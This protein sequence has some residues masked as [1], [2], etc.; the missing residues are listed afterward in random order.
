[1]KKPEKLIV[2]KLKEK[3]GKLTPMMEQYLEIKSQYRDVL[4]LFRMGDFYEV[5]FEDA[6]AT[7][8]ILNIALTHRGKLAGVPIPMAGIPHHAASTYID[9][10]TQSGRK[11]AICEQ[12]EDPKQAKGI[13]KR[14]VTQIVSPSIPY[15]LDKSEERH[16]HYLC[17]FHFHK[18]VTYAS[19]IDYTTGDFFGLEIK[20]QEELFD[21]IKIYAPRECIAFFDQ[22]ERRNELREFLENRDVLITYLSSEFFQEKITASYIEKIIPYYKKDN[23]LKTHKEFIPPIGALSYYICSTQGCEKLSHFSAFSV[24]NNQKKMKISHQTLASLEI[25]PRSQEKFSHSLLAFINKTKTSMGFRK[26][27]EFSQSPLFDKNEI[28][29]RLDCVEFLMANQSDL[30]NIRTELDEIRDLKRILAK[31]STGKIQSQDL[32]N[33]KVAIET[34]DKLTK[35][36]KK[37]T[38]Y[39]PSHLDKNQL[40][41]LDEL[42]I[43]IGKAINDE[44]GANLNKGNLIKEKYSK[45]RDELANIHET[46]N[47]KMKALEDKYRKKHDISNL[48]IKF[49]N[50]NGYFIEVSKAQLAK[51]PETFK[52]KQTLVNCGRFLTAEVQKV[53]AELYSA[54][55]KLLQI[56]R[57]IF[58]KICKQTEDNVLAIQ[59]LADFLAT[60]DIYQSF[61]WLA[62]QENFSRPQI[63]DKKICHLEGVWHPLIKKAIHDQ[64][65]PHNIELNNKQY[66]ALITGPNM[67]GKTT[68]MREV[69][70]VQFLTQMGSYVPAA[71]AQ[72]GLCDYI[73]SRIGASD[74]IVGGQSTFM[75]EMSE[76]SEILRH[77]SEHSLLILDEIG[78]GTST[79]DGLSIAWS[80]LEHFCEKTKALTL[81]ST[82]YH[83]LIDVAE[84][85][86]G[87]INLTVK[88]IN[89]NGT[90]QFLYELIPGGAT[91]S[92]G[93]HVAKLAGLPS[94][95]LKRANQILKQLEKEQSPK[96]SFATINQMN[97]FDSGDEFEEKESMIE[98][99]IREIDINSMTPIE[100]LNKFIEFQTTLQKSWEDSSSL[101]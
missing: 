35:K 96:D 32:L 36:I 57:E 95:V 17:S 78:R 9:K 69:A 6:E 55:E 68:V 43:L 56:E 64:F 20:S 77:A 45:K 3:A 22:F 34:F 31:L 7:S 5:F 25:F 89:K 24:I 85:T 99:Q 39:L 66:F 71:K 67:A 100:A 18:N 79:F 60:L 47:S 73:F 93:I 37:L 8:K 81:F 97:L 62:F 88:T 42:S 26:L 101:Q 54:Q 46:V 21:K 50:I 10:I 82:H 23:T 13:V 90:I 48:K 51:V 70:I 16:N 2:E 49:N 19:F 4:L 12:V 38:T 74:D 84:Q 83:E 40:A 98:N 15:D 59:R 91:Q 29:K 61:A 72:V 52:K 94:S 30:N 44:I 58:K 53:E 92:F 65:V 87:A 41:A 14:A 1:M 76:T 28:E 86:A 80:L 75:V 27:K 33:L 11:V 63:E